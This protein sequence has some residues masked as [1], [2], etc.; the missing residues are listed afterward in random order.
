MLSGSLNHV[1]YCKTDV[2]DLEI[3]TFCPGVPSEILNPRNTW[4]DSRA[5]DAKADYL[6]QLFIENMEQYIE[7]A[8]EEIVN[9]GPKASV[10]I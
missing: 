9:A 2:F 7:F 5:Y 3:P 6:A 8:K 1:R 4:E 10:V